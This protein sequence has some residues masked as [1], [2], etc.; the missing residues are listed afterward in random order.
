MNCFLCG[1]NEDYCL[2]K[3]PLESRFQDLAVE[4]IGNAKPDEYI[5]LPCFGYQIDWVDDDNKR[6]SA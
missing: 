4:I 2:L 6:N 3:L 1:R 5:C